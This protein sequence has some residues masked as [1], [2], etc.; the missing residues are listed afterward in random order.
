MMGALVA[1]YLYK[2]AT[3][4]TVDTPVVPTKTIS[5]DQSVG[6]SPDL[7]PE[8]QKDGT[9]QPSTTKTPTPT[10]STQTPKSAEQ[11]AIE[12][13]TQVA[14]RQAEIE[15]TITKEYEYRALA[16]TPNDP[17]YGTFTDKKGYIHTPFALQRL[18]APN[19][20]DVTTGSQTIIANIDT[21]YALNHEDLK[22]QWYQ[23]PGENGVATIAQDAHGNT[24]KPDADE[25]A[26]ACDDDNNGYVD[27]W[28][29]WNFY[30]KYTPTATPCSLTGLGTYIPNNNPMA[31]TAGDDIAY[32]ENRDCH[33]IDNGDPFNAVSHGT[34][35]AGIIG[36][37]SN[38]SIGIATL[39]WSVKIMP[40]QALGDDGSGW[41]SKIVSAI[42]Y[43]VDNGANIINMSL[44]GP[45]NDPAL[46][47]AIDYA[48]NHNVI[49]VAAAGNCGTGKESGCDP[50]KRGEMGYPALNNHVIAVGATDK[51]DVRASFS[52][53]GPGLDIVAPGY[54]ELVA[55]LIDRPVDTATNKPSIDP[56]TFNY[57]GAYSAGLAGTSFASPYVANLVSLIKSVK[58]SYSVD[59][60]T[61]ILD[62][63]ATKL[64]GMNGALYTQQYG[65]GLA[66]A[67]AVVNIAKNLPAS[68]D[69]PKLA[70]T[71]DYRSEHSFSPTALMSS[72]CTVSANKYCTV[73]M[74][75]NNTGYD[76]YLPYTITANGQSGWQWSGSILTPGEWSVRSVQGKSASSS[77]LLFSK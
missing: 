55:P 11:P 17:M 32:K 49:V 75:D 3:I 52:S 65:H 20:W 4:A 77:Y 26:N 76:R 48:Y 25:S 34:S 59:D 27:D 62:G 73:W 1:F 43:A 31:G 24:C 68:A 57:T 28:R 45:E 14:P 12:A 6:G 9:T 53:Y 64:S 51:N 23:N 41:T 72:G 40:L 44:G 60:V 54:G 18:G 10:E 19:V 69:T 36:A 33:C 74:H 30:G 15:K 50:T 22:N 70:Q 37:T 61:A 47:A 29:G 7:E 63:S 46:R 21:G 66:N 5:H 38:N 56:L 42:Y 39:N 2:N 71:G 35:S 8:K 16:I 58:P 13:V 67:T